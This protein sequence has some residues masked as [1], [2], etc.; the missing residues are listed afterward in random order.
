MKRIIFIMFAAAITISMNAC[1]I[2]KQKTSND[3]A[4]EVSGIYTGILPCASCHG[5]R[6]RV[7]LNAD[8]TYTLQTRY[9]DR[10]DE[11]FTYSGKF[12]WDA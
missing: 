10:S 7:D 11:T 2:K 5:I 4:Q 8:L 9:I 1:K 12:I 6:T 3:V